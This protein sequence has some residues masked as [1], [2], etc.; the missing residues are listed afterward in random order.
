MSLVPLCYL[1]SNFGLTDNSPFAEAR[2]KK[3]K[4]STALVGAV[5]HG[6]ALLGLGLALLG[7]AF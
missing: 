3:K 4:L 6:L 7:E 1:P 5:S 2:N